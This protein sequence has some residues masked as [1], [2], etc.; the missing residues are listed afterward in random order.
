MKK[1]L[2]L[3]FGVLFGVYGLLEFYIPHWAVRTTTEELQAWAALLT[4]AAFILGGVNILQVTWPK[5]RR[6]EEDWQYKVLLLGCAALMLVVGLPWH[7]LGGA[8]E[9]K[10]THAVVGGMPVGSSAGGGRIVIAAP[11]DVTVTIGAV[12]AP[13]T[14]AN[15][16]FTLDVPAGETE[17][18]LTRRVAGYRALTTKVNVA[19]GQ[20]IEVRG[21]PPMTWGRDG[22]VFVW[23]YDHVF[24]PCNSTMFAL[25]AFFV[26]SAAFRAFRARNAEAA[27]LLAAAILVMLGRAPLGRSISDVFP[28]FGQWLIDIPNNA[29]R[30]AI[31]MGAAIG[32]IATALRV[33]VGLERSHLGSD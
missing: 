9:A 8:D 19:E 6:R 16:P 3:A 1:L 24:D 14:S 11:S 22:R 17:V 25:L 32:A 5:I 4:A 2:P 26:A 28:D 10:A 12:T 20:I 30:R 27:L 18:V 13:A 7:K 33:I 15:K 23:I 21:D 31:M 29:G